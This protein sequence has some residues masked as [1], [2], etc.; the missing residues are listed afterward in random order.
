MS[1]LPLP[2]HTQI[3]QWAAEA[4]SAD[5][6]RREGGVAKLS[7]AIY[8]LEAEVKRLNWELKS[9]NEILGRKK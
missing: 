2:T 3:Y 5:P 1:P 7:R 9:V 4:D 6:R 8:T